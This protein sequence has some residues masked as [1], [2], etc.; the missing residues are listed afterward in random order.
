MLS[1]FKLRSIVAFN[2]RSVHSQLSQSC[3]S[4]CSKKI[5]TG[6][7]GLQAD[8]N[9][10]QNLLEL[11]TELNHKLSVLPEDFAYRK[12]MLVLLNSRKNLIE[13]EAYSDLD[14]E[15]EIGEGQLEELVEQ[16]EDELKLVEKL[17]NEWKPWEK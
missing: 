13:N 12:G 14:L 1:L 16:A 7:T 2:L 6:L 17:V 8:S 5:S 10:R 3:F 11:Y 15:A 9:S 4:T